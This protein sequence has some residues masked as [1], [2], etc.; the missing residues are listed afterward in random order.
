MRL[1]GDVEDRWDE[2]SQAQWKSQALEELACLDDLLVIAGKVPSHNAWVHAGSDHN[3]RV[4]LK[5]KDPGGW[6]PARSIRAVLRVDVM[7]DVRIIGSCDWCRWRSR[8][9]LG[10]NRSL[11]WCGRWLRRASASIGAG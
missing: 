1:E 11:G 5:F 9:T 7:V 10:W 3:V 4:E 2:G 6:G 8:A